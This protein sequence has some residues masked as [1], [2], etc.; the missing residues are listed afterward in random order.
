MNG[1]NYVRKQL[2]EAVNEDLANDRAEFDAADVTW[3]ALGAGTRSMAG[4][5]I[6]KFVT[7]DADSIPLIYIDSGGFPK[8]ASGGDVTLQFNTEGIM[9]LANAA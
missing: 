6:F 3:T 2:T 1:T 9:Q 4:A 7:N 8:A 5:V